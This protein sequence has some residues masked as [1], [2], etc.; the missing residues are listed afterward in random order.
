MTS[1]LLARQL[2]SIFS[3]RRSTFLLQEGG[4]LAAAMV[5]NYAS[6]MMLLHGYSVV[7]KTNWELGALRTDMNRGLG[8]IRTDINKG[9]GTVMKTLRH[10][11]DD[12][13]EIKEQ[14]SR[15]R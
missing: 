10:I 14:E 7:K 6:C 13:E 15:K 8:E 11:K 5:F 9:F 1:P 3:Q 12:L 4:Y 2:A